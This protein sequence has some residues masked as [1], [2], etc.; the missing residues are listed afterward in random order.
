MKI[1]ILSV[2]L[3]VLTACSG[4]G[5]NSVV[6]EGNGEGQ[7]LIRFD[8]TEHDLG[9]ILEGEIVGYNFEFTN[10]GESALLIHEARTSC[11]CTVPRYSKKPVK[12][13]ESGSIEVVFD[14]SGRMGQQM[15][16]VIILSNASEPSVK[17][18]ITADIYK[19]ES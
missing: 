18:T 7:A 6:A 11:G 16:S 4:I 15:K 1:N 17:L 12:P 3:L 10:E 14:S 9:R 19:S 13:G 5:N 8:K 2:L